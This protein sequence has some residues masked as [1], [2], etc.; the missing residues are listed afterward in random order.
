MAQDTNISTDVVTVSR[1]ILPVKP[2]DFI[3]INLQ[4][5]SLLCIM[6]GASLLL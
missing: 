6:L 5:E 1:D 3:I 4:P 2:N